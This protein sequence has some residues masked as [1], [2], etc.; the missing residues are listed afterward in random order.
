GPGNESQLEDIIITQEELNMKMEEGLKQKNSGNPGED[1]DNGSGQ[2]NGE[3]GEGQ[4]GNREEMNG[5]LFEIFKQQQM[6]KQQL[7]NKLREMGIDPLS[8]RLLREMD[9]VEKDILDK[10]YDRN[11]LEKMNRITHRLLELE[12]AEREQEEDEERRAETNLKEF[13]NPSQ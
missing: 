7:E 4:D 9:Q 6:L 3:K 8:S 11:T 10:G 1:G 5:N 13:E 2:E 12:S